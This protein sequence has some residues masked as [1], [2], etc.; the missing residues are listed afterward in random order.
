MTKRSGNTSSG[1]A[2]GSSAFVC[3]LS[4][5]F[6][7][8]WILSLLGVTTRNEKF[9]FQSLTKSLHW[10]TYLHAALWR[11]LTFPWLQNSWN[12]KRTFLNVFS[13]HF[14]SPTFIV[15]KNLSNLV[16]LA[17]VLTLEPYKWT[18][19]YTHILP[20]LPLY[21][22]I[23]TF[24]ENFLLIYLVNLKKNCLW[25]EET[26]KRR[27]IAPAYFACQ[28]AHVTSVKEAK[29]SKSPEESQFF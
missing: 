16:A 21:W 1:T 23:S 7:H 5:W 25:W 22:L 9:D 18:T 10:F 11:I 17:T 28:F 8:A 3:V 4:V 15:C 14:Y 19:I 29:S 26:Y 2:T 13:F 6:V 12:V 27:A 20:W 24:G